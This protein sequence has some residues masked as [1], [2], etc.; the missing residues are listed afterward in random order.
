MKRLFSKA[1]FALYR[2]TTTNEVIARAISGLSVP[3]EVADV[4]DF[5]GGLHSF[6]S[7]QLF[8]V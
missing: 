4:L 5:I 2:H 3:E 1:V 6:P 8:C 7:T